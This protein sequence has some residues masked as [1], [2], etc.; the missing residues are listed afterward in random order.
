[1]FRYGDAEYST[2]VR[3]G[4]WCI[5]NLEINA[6][7]RARRAGA[8]GAVWYFLYTIGQNWVQYTLRLGRTEKS[9]LGGELSTL[10]AQGFSARSEQKARTAWAS[11]LYEIYGTRGYRATDG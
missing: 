2:Q 5:G 1:M 11:R 8:A 9:E 6:R 10:P 7:A 3:G 4:G